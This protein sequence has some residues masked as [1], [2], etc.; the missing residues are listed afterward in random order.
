LVGR[1]IISVA[2]RAE[3][4]SHQ[5]DGHTPRSAREGADLHEGRELGL[6][7]PGLCQTLTAMPREMLL[8]L[9]H[10]RPLTVL[11]WLKGN[12]ISTCGETARMTQLMVGGSRHRPW[13]KALCFRTHGLCSFDR[14]RR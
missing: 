5:G 14:N 6:P 7:S 2:W 13:L 1:E 4:T 12:A 3:G 9:G 8:R 10:E 11:N